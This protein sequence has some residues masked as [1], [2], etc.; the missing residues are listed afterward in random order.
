MK[1]KTF[2]QRKV[3]IGNAEHAGRMWRSSA[4]FLG[5][6]TV[7]VIGIGLVPFLR[8]RGLLAGV[9]IGCAFTLL[10][11]AVMRAGNAQV[12]GAWAERWSL[13]SLR[14][15][16]G[17]LVT[18]NLP[19]QDVDVDHVAVTPAAVLAIETKYH[20]PGYDAATNLKR[21][22]R[23]LDAAQ[24]AE[25][26]VSSYLRSLK[27]PTPVPTS[28]VLMVW[29]PGRPRLAGGWREE[30]RVLVVDADNPELWSHRFAAP[31]I[32]GDLRAE[33]HRRISD[34]VVVRHGY[35]SGKIPPLRREMAEAFRSGSRQER[36]ERRARKELQRS[37]RRRHRA[38]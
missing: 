1:Q 32:G 7:A 11:M 22:R 23:D 30:D 35:Q 10:A 16:S 38:T 26:K 21:H 3:L 34:Y 20:G 36:E 17:W 24:A 25:R 15:V 19:F 8:W 2:A 9:I 27:L 13:E 31:L 12:H 6:V 33:I 29:G 4:A 28:A 5:W 14:K 18:E 37:L